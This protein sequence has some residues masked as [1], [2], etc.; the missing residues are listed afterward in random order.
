MLEDTLTAHAWY[1]IAGANGDDMVKGN[2]DKIARRMTP[3]QIVRAQELSRV[4]LGQIEG[5][6]AGGSDRFSPTIAPRVD[7]QT[8]LPT[9]Y[10]L[11]S[12]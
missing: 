11:N 9:R 1:N 10:K 3:E 2:K 6:Q 8:G 5:K 12:K 4:L 7:T